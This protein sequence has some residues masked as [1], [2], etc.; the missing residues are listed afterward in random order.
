M[1]RIDIAI[2]TRKIIYFSK[3][4]RTAYLWLILQLLLYIQIPA[5]TIFSRGRSRT[6]LLLYYCPHCTPTLYN[7]RYTTMGLEIYVMHSWALHPCCP[8]CKVAGGRT[9]YVALVQRPWNTLIYHDVWRTSQ[10]PL[11]K[12]KCFDACH[13]FPLQCR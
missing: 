1:L 4:V 11:G 2:I 7:F 3:Y 10:R 13:A 9:S 8:C 6:L 12:V 5:K